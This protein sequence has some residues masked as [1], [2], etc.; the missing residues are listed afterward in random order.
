MHSMQF[1]YTPLPKRLNAFTST[2]QI[3]QII[4]IRA[5][6]TRELAEG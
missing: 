3:F 5:I 4:T 1:S 2:A 6:R